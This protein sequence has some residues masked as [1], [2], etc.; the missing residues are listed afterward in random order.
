[1][2]VLESI[3][4]HRRPLVDGLLQ[5]VQLRADAVALLDVLDRDRGSDFDELP[6]L[7]LAVPLCEEGVVTVDGSLELGESGASSVPATVA[8]MASYST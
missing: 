6:S 3:E 5:R 8:S 4:L 7:G 1:M 2:V